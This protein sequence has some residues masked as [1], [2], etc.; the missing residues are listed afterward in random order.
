MF[1]E[2]VV[3]EFNLDTMRFG[4]LVAITDA[5]N[6]FGRIWREGAVSLGF[7]VH[8]DCTTAGHGPGFTTIMTSKNGLIE[9]VITPDA[10][11]VKWI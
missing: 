11:L 1:D 9:P 4:D 3:K 6:T 10:N 5:D 7:I 2:S 8:S